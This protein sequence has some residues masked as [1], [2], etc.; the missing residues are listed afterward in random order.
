MT[1]QKT[2]F[3]LAIIAV[4][5]SGA[6]ITALIFVPIPEGNR[7]PLML[8]LGL[9]LGLAVTAY[10]FYFGTSESSAQKTELLADRPSGREGDE[11]HTEEKK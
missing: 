8:A 7:E 6:I 5:V 11:I 10:Q 3:V 9:V 1:R 2:R 4:L